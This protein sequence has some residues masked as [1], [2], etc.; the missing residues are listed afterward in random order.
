MA[1]LT[2]TAKL[3]R[4]F[5]RAMKDEAPR[6]ASTISSQSPK[7]STTSNWPT[8]P[9]ASAGKTTAATGITAANVPGVT[10]TAP[11]TVGG[12]GGNG[13]QKGG[14]PL[15]EECIVIKRQFASIIPAFDP[16]PGSPLF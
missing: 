13:T 8:L 15:E 4:V 6:S 1:E 2:R 14:Q 11:V 16:R 12:A 9:P 3:S 5:L 10:A 7:P